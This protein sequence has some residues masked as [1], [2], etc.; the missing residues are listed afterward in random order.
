MDKK[1][2]SIFRKQRS[3]SARNLKYNFINLPKDIIE[4]IN[5]NI[6]QIWIKSETQ[7]NKNIQAQDIIFNVQ[8]IF[9]DKNVQLIDQFW[10]EHCAASLRELVDKG[11]TFNYPKF[12][13]HLPKKDYSKKTE[14]INKKLEKYKNFLSQFV[15]FNKKATNSAGTLLGFENEVLEFIDPKNFDKL[16]TDFIWQLYEY[17]I[18][19]IELHKKIDE[20]L[21]KSPKSSEIKVVN[22]LILSNEDL[23]EY[24]YTKVDERWLDS[25]W[26]SVFFGALNKKL[27]DGTRYYCNSELNYLHRMAEKDPEKVIDIMLSIKISRNNFHPQ[28]IQN[29]LFICELLPT[30]Q[31]KK[32][33]KKI[34]KN[35]WVEFERNSHFLYEI[36]F[37]KVA[38]NKEYD[39][40]L[41]L[42]EIILKLK[43]KK[44]FKLKKE[45]ESSGIRKKFADTKSNKVS[46]FI[47]FAPSNY[48]YFHFNFEGSTYI[49]Y[50]EYLTNINDEYTEKMLKLFCE[51]IS[52]IVKL[53][54]KTDNPKDVFAFKNEIYLNNLDFFTLDLNKSYQTSL[55]DII[56]K[57]LASIKKLVQKIFDEHCVNT[58]LIISIYNKYFKAL[59]DNSLTWKLKLFVLSLC[60]NTLQDNLKDAFARLFDA[61]KLNKDYYDIQAGTEY[62]TTLKKSFK[63]FNSD[64]HRYFVNELFKYLGKSCKNTGENLYRKQVGWEILSSICEF[65]TEEEKKKCVIF[66]DKK[67]DLKFL[68]GPFPSITRM[69]NRVSKGVVSQ[70][71]FNN[72]SIIEIVQKLKTEWAPEQLALLRKDDDFLSP[73]ELAGVK[74]QLHKDIGQ[75]PKEYLLN[76]NLFFDRNNLDIEYIVAF[77]EGIWEVIKNNFSKIQTFN[78]GELIDLIFK[79]TQSKNN[80]NKNFNN[81]F[82]LILNV[83]KELFQKK[84]PKQSAIT[85]NKHRDKLFKIVTHLLEFTKSKYK[86]PNILENNETEN[87]SLFN[88]G[89]NTGYGLAIE[90][91]IFFTFWQSNINF[92]KQNKNKIEIEEDVKKVYEKFL[93]KKRDPVLM[94]MF[95]WF[96]P[97][98]YVRYK[99][100]VHQLLPIIFP[101]AQNERELFWA[102][103]EGYLRNDVY[104]NIFI[105]CKFRKIYEK[106]I[107]LANESLDNLNL[108][109]ITKNTAEHIALIFVLYHEN[110]KFEDPLFKKFWEKNT[111]RQA[112]FI[113]SIGADFISERYEWA[114]KALKK[115]FKIKERLIT[116]WEWV[117]KNCDDSKVF[118]NFYYWINI[119]SKIFDSKW[120]VEKV[121]ETLE[122]SK[123]I[124]E[125]DYK[126]EKNIS[127]FIEVNIQD[128][129]EIVRLFLLEGKL[130]NKKN[131]SF[132][133][134]GDTVNTWIK[135][136]ETLYDNLK[137]KKATR[138][139]IAELLKVGGKPF[140]KFKKIIEKNN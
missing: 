65:L 115:D 64:Y 94:Y 54:G 4:T 16:C 91:F 128:T 111:E 87:S 32:I 114:N 98:F 51:T 49:K 133:F 84:T 52:K 69:G 21:S 85:L 132:W 116:L 136:F 102:T 24:F 68:P 46:D 45:H 124:L 109:K 104:E 33:V 23:R 43:T 107:E 119:K 74:S 77:F 117:L 97:F 92:K 108:E 57:L 29:F 89:F 15:H 88:E 63:V 8:A 34:H 7:Y 134:R 48:D 30:N 11:F 10:M 53:Q 129:L 71:V 135:I 80:S 138:I 38:E 130:K 19:Q 9:Q 126:F 72:F 96:F 5:S 131:N 76:V 59:P 1:N 67:C 106:S 81:L 79:I 31:L 99:N 58:S 56:E 139:L 18:D 37:K 86:K 35:K 118:E 103:W 113:K 25:L 123:G 82:R 20:L 93:K 3:I 75:R 112:H 42:A 17:F 127:K 6:N 100:W 105:D 55:P 120:L 90:T 22:S 78:G 110:F 101:F 70:E 125:V 27:E 95:G 122:K 83:L 137:T 2:D 121:K 140:W 14:E 13:E 39:I 73:I 47:Y 12:S 44:H 61:S 60:P 62:K 66:F 26:Q 41:I 36:L 40:L 50:F 28:I